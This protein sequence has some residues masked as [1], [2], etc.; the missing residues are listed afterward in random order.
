MVSQLA[1]IRARLSIAAYDRYDAQELCRVGG[2]F[3]NTR[4]DWTPAQKRRMQKRRKQLD[5]R[6]ARILAANNS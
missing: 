2:K 3:E 4:K 6:A 5:K 1:V